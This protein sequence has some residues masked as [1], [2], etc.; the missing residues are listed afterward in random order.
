MYSLGSNSDQDYYSLHSQLSVARA[1]IET[2]QNVYEETMKERNILREDLVRLCPSPSDTF[3][4]QPGSVTGQLPP[5]SGV[6]RKASRS[7]EESRRRT[8]E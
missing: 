4:S 5:R 2:L 6:G 3:E 1:E 8:S 7:S